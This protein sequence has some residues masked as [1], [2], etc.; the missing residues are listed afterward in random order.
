MAPSQ[1][2]QALNV[3]YYGIVEA[4]A[5]NLWARDVINLSYTCKQLRQAFWYGQLGSAYGSLLPHTMRCNGSSGRLWK[6]EVL[7]SAFRTPAERAQFVPDLET[8]APCQ[9]Q[10]VGY[11]AS[12]PCTRCSRPICRTCRVRTDYQQIAGLVPLRESGEP[13]GPSGY[14][15]A[16]EFQMLYR[17]RLCVYCDSCE[18]GI[19]ASLAAAATADG[20]QAKQCRCETFLCVQ[21][22][23]ELDVE[24]L[25]LKEVSR[26]EM[27]VRKVV[28]RD[29]VMSWS[30]M[31]EAR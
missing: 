22:F 9:S 15:F 16:T 8:A 14:V 7:E 13:R 28:H 3:A 19:L 18:V 31:L 23:K 24:Y 10:T 27:G 6:Q 1:L 20:G 30:R 29:V 25:K 5:S 21:C 11:L 4:V 17:N 26:T 2:F 12:D